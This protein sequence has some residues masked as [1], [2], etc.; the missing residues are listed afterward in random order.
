MKTKTFTVKTDGFAG[1]LYE[2][3]DESQYAVLMVFGGATGMKM[4]ALFAPR[5]VNNGI[6]ALVISL[7][8][9]EGLKLT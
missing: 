7:F 8:G 6:A 4:G 2:P 9:M 3:D 1:M 5:F